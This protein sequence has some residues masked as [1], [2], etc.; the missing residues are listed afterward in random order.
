MKQRIITLAILAS[1]AL[2]AWRFVGVRAAGSE[3]TYDFVEVAR[4]S[5]E[6]VVSGTGTLSAVGTVEVSTQVSG[7]LATIFVDYNDTVRSGQLL[8]ELDP[9]KRLEKVNAVLASEI[10]VLGLKKD[11]DEKVRERASN[12]QR[13]FYLREQKKII[14]ALEEAGLRDEVKVLVGGSPVTQAWAEQIGADGYAQDAMSAVD[15]AFRLL[16]APA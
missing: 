5:L 11:I 14:E 12:M 7:R 4:G 6:N 2:M 9:V 8:A 16:D 1:V 10:E 13:D 15:L 3:A